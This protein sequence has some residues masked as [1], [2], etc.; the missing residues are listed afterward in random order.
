MKRSL[1]KRERIRKKAE[2]NQVFS[3]SS[4]VGCA[5]LKLVFRTNNLEFNRFAVTAMKRIGN[6]VRRNKAKRQVREIFRD[7]KPS[8]LP[9]FDFVLIVYSGARVYEERREQI[10]SL[11]ERAGVI[12]SKSSQ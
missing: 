10:R 1:T 11:M 3:H 4:R 12:S 7:L 2:F 6:A 9:G 8:L 5:G